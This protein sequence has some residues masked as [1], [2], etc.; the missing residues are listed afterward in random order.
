MPIYKYVAVFLMVI[1]TL[2]ASPTAAKD[3]IKNLWLVKADGSEAKQIT[4]NDDP[5]LFLP[6]DLSPDGKHIVT[7][8]SGKLVFYDLDGNLVKSMLVSMPRSDSS[9]SDVNWH[10]DDVIS[11]N[12]ISYETNASKESHVWYTFKWPDGTRERLIDLI[13]CSSSTISPDRNWALISRSSGDG[14]YPL[15]LVNTSTGAENA[16][17]YEWGIGRAWSPSSEYVAF[18]DFNGLYIVDTNGRLVSSRKDVA[19]SDISWA[20][21]NSGLLVRSYADGLLLISPT[22]Q[23]LRSVPSSGSI[24]YACL[25]ADNSH[26]AYV[27]V[28]GKTEDPIYSLW[29]SDLSHSPTK[30]IEVDGYLL[31]AEWLPNNR[32]LVVRWSGNSPM[33]TPQLY[34]QEAQAT[35]SMSQTTDF[36]NV[37]WGMTKSEV[38]AAETET[39]LT[40]STSETDLLI[41][42]V[43]VAGMDAVLYYEFGADG[44]LRQAV[45]S[46]RTEHTNDNL[47]IE[48]FN[49]LKGLLTSKYGAPA[50]DKPLWKNDF[51]K[52]HPDGWGLAVSR[53]DV[54]FGATWSTPTTE[55]TLLLYGDNYKVSHNL[56]Y[57]SSKAKPEPKSTSGL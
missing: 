37:R 5:D 38:I 18:E 24:M 41:G 15:Y 57:V 19:F 17:A 51:F 49:R 52:E 14:D 29:L 21:D 10:T 6:W 23:V 42:F 7:V 40:S 22:G 8:A 33:P 36:R 35:A 4:H 11:Y 27:R 34:R 32:A 28:D 1:S 43:T 2:F 54:T 39:K 13:D 9:I 46:F 53:G 56:Y 30:L 48:D 25:T 3:T 45:Y 47:Y 12:V 16:L 31:D 26:L 44:L 20:P 55:I 50:F